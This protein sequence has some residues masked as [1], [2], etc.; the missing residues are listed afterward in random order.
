MAGHG[1]ACDEAYSLYDQWGKI[2]SQTKSYRSAWRLPG[3]IVLS[4][5][6]GVATL[7]KK[8]QTSQSPMSPHCQWLTE[9]C[10]WLSY[11]AYTF[12]TF[13][14]RRSGSGTSYSRGRLTVLLS[15]TSWHIPFQLIRGSRLGL[16]MLP[17]TKSPDVPESGVQAACRT[18]LI[19]SQMLMVRREDSHHD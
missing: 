14:G 7:D 12:S 13:F 10:S 1:G 19:G 18:V 2:V 11:P 9:L 17:T 8:K 15:V 3:W 16:A 5:G 6:A 4:R